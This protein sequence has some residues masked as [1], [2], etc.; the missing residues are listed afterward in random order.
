MEIIFEIFKSSWQILE[1]AALYLL[2]GFVIAGILRSLVSEDTVAKYLRSGRFKSVFYSSLLGIPFP[3][4]SCGVV[5]AVAGFK[6]QG[7]NNGA[8]LAFLTST[9]ETGIDSIALTYSLLGPILTAM[10]P[11]TAFISAMCAGLLENYTGKSYADSSQTIVNPSCVIDGCCDSAVCDPQIDK[12]RHTFFH[13][14]H[15]GIKF[16]FNELMGD[17]AVWFVIG[18]FLAGIIHVLVPSSWVNAALGSGVISYLMAIIVSGPMYVCATLS[19]PVTAA[20]VMKGMSPGAALVMLMVGPATNIP[21]IAMVGGL[22]GKRALGIYV[23]SIVAISVAMAY[24][25]DIIYQTFSIPPMAYLGL[26]GE[27]FLWTQAELIAAII[28]SALILR[29][30]WRN[31]L[32]LYVDRFLLGRNAALSDRSHKCSCA[33]NCCGAPGQKSTDEKAESSF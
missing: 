32:R 11:V 16:A 26:T 8:C 21:T 3:L 14:L 5:P 28:L 31:Y 24:V 23:G 17:L 1:S 10:R 29:V 9:P 33:D 7:A 18:I 30:F 20:L 27:S 13:K 6:R 4:C 25:T 15:A 2:F 12:R 19:T 22:L